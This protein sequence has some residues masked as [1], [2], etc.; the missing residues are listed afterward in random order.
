V[1][2]HEDETAVWV[3]AARDSR[4]AVEAALRRRDLAPRA[5]ERLE[6]VKAVALGY[7]LDEVARWSG[8][9]ERT[10]GRWLGAFAAGGLAA[11]ADAPRAGRPPRADAAYLA[12]LE[13]AVDTP[14][15]ALGLP[16]DAWTSARLSAYL[17]ETRGVRIAPGWIRALL[18]RRRYRT[19][20]PKHTL[21]HLQDPAA[22][23]ACEQTLRVVGEKGG[24]GGRA[25]RAALPG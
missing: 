14:P 10:V 9:T 19:G 6:M 18:A 20:R 2:D 25:V 1:G 7:A 8:R 23:A 4:A 22:E 24:G 16:F 12:A 11:V 5:R 17:A 21:G 13:A 15:P 3:R